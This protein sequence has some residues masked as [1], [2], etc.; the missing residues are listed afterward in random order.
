MLPFSFVIA[1]DETEEEVEDVVVLGVKQSL[2]DAIELKRRLI[3]YKIF[4]SGFARF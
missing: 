4:L 2:I 3:Y 1:Q